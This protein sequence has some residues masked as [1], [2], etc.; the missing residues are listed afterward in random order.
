VESEDL[1]A[2]EEE[3]FQSV[4][5]WV[6]EDEAGRKAELDRLLPLVRFP[7]MADAPS[8]I[9]AEPLVSQHPL[10]M[11]LLYETTPGFA[12][13]DITRLLRLRHPRLRPRGGG[14]A[15]QAA[16]NPALLALLQL[17]AGAPAGKVRD[18]LN[19]KD[20]NRDLP[21]HRA[22][23]DAATGPERVHT[24]L[25][26][27]SEAMLAVPGSGKW[28]PLHWAARFSLSPAVVA[29]LLA[30]GP[31]EALWARD[32]DGCTPLYHAEMHNTGPAA[33]EIAALLRAAT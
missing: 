1:E 18:A 28:L 16:R 2:K 19:K 4:I 8:A 15:A 32:W 30:S 6:K 22:L 9:M 25:D 23:N 26:A 12:K 21:I 13:S 17:P 5:N 3:V 14:A 33:A 11:Q 7:L 27:G 20:W 31:A 24:M 29:L 10:G